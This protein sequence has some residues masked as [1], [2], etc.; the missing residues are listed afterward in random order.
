MECRCRTGLEW[1]STTQRLSI[2]VLYL[3]M[4][5]QEV[6]ILLTGGDK[7]SQ[8]RDIEAARALAKQYQEES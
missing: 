5:G 3:T 6:V 7:G 4:R 2:R 8:S 1:S